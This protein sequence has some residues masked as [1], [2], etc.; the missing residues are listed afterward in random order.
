MN[1]DKPP[2]KRKVAGI[3]RPAVLPGR[4]RNR[5]AKGDAPPHVEASTTK[6]ARLAALGRP[7]TWGGKTLVA[8]ISAVA[9]AAAVAIATPVIG[10]SRISDMFRSGPDVAIR[11]SKIFDYGSD[12]MAF[13]GEF[14]LAPDEPTRIAIGPDSAAT[15][16]GKMETAGGVPLHLL[17]LRIDVRGNRS[18]EVRVTGLDVIELR[19][20]AALNGTLVSYGQEGGNEPVQQVVFD[21]DSAVPQG[22]LPTRAQVDNSVA[23][24]TKPSE[25]FFSNYSLPIKDNETTSI[26]AQFSISKGAATFDLQLDYTLDGKPRQMLIPGQFATSALSCGSQTTADYDRAYMMTTNP[27]T[28]ALVLQEQA[29]PHSIPVTGCVH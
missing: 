28:G 8:A 11:T 22:L 15:L 20:S 25:M 16:L 2:V 18:S 9:L 27:G 7:F 3:R 29:D 24:T 17:R 21:L 6:A 4:S 10:V 1:V 19:R 26:I 12:A 14:T 5:T 13:G 23:P